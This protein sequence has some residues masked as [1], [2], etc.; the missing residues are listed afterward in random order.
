MTD[1]KIDMTDPG[2]D[3]NLAGMTEAERIEYHRLYLEIAYLCMLVNPHTEY[4]VFFDYSGHVWN[5]TIRIKRSK[6][7]YNED[8]ADAEFK[9]VNDPTKQYGWQGN[10]WLRKKRD[11]LLEIL[12][13]NEVPIDQLDREVIQTYAYS[14]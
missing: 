3:E 8:V 6:K 1:Q 12:T 14:F 10:D 4:C 9:V 2:S 13:T 7:A 11:I 5:V